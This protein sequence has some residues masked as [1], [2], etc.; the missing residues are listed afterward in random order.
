VA[1]FKK[2]EKDFCFS[3]VRCSPVSHDKAFLFKYL[4]SISNPCF[5]DNDESLECN[6]AAL[7]KLIKTKLSPTL[8]Q[9]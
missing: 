5:V 6:I 8:V 9:Y 1:A 2:I 7:I 3:F 4:D